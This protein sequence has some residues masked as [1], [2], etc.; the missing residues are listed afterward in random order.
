MR[1]IGE[2]LW[3][4]SS[5]QRLPPDDTISDM[6]T[7]IFCKPAGER[8]Y[9]QVTAWVIIPFLSPQLDN[10]FA[11]LIIITFVTERRVFR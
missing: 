7:Q 10:L 5:S 4:N 3:Q 8:Y 6:K 11:L 1:D 2:R 9:N